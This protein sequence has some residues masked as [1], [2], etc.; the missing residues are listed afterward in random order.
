VFSPNATGGVLSSETIP[1]L[2]CRIVAGAANNQLARPEDAELF[3]PLGIL[4]APDYVINA[5]GII[6]LASLELLGED[7]A[8]CD[9]RLLGIADTLTEVFEAADAAGI[10]TGAAAERIVERRLAAAA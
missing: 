9:E 4:Y 7:E 1:E 8:K 2:R 5:G 10:S 3:G 6:H